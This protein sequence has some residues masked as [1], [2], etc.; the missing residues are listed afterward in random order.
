MRCSLPPH[1]D[2][3]CFASFEDYEIHYKK[4]HTNRCLECRK[5]FP[6]EHFLNL[7][8]EENH[9]ALVSVKKE[10]G[11]RTYSCFVEDCVRKCST[12]QKRRMHLI[13]KHLFPKDYD[14]RIVDQGIDF[15]SSMLR[16]GRN[17][18]R[19]SAAHH[20]ADAD[21]RERRRSSLLQNP[22][23]G[24]KEEIAEAGEKGSLETPETGLGASL[25]KPEDD[26]VMEG[27][28]RTMSSLKF[29]PPSIRFGRRSGQGRG[30]FSKV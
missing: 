25:S 9:D 24:K 23:E 2:T 27:L 1:R 3:L 29:V 15:R 19:S 4:D 8:I 14:F 11:D 12:P 18:R 16:S 30:G 7:H 28:T 13:D 26:D 22:H 20:K 6:T 10:R 17:R 21:G 5:N